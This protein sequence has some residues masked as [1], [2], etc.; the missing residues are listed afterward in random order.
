MTADSGRR[1]VDKFCDAADALLGEIAK[2]RQ[3][4]RRPAQR[5]RREP[6]RANVPRGR[7][8]ARTGRVRALVAAAMGG[9]CDIVDGPRRESMARLAGRRPRRRG[10]PGSA[11]RVRRPGAG[12]SGH[13][14][15]RHGGI[16]PRSRGDRPRAGSAPGH[17]ALHVLDSSD[18]GQIRTVT[19]AIDPARNLFISSPA[20]PVRRWSRNCCGPISSIW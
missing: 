19:A 10:G 15:A 2:T 11:Q 7:G 3:D 12:I 13:R 5:P 9:R 17:P 20:N 18:P 16:K 6:A 8:Q 1:G 4:A 14:A